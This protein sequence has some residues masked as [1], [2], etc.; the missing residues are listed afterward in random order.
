MTGVVIG[1][2][3]MALSVAL[4]GWR[5]LAGPDDADRAIASDLLFFAVVGL[6]AMLGTLLFSEV[7]F[8]VVL[9]A[10]VVGF[11]ASVS[12]ARAIT[13]GRR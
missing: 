13:R 8:D 10:A 6:F 7:V 11:L 2:V 4:A 12:L 1:V 5:M 9:I 3:L